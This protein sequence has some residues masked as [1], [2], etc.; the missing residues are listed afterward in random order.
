M[1]ALLQKDICARSAGTRQITKIKTKAKL[2]KTKCWTQQ[3][4]PKKI[5]YNFPSSS[6]NNLKKKKIATLNLYGFIKQER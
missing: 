2:R 3:S 6:C 5:Y 4:S 1:S